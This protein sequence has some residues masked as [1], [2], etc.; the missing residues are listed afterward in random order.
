M[1]ITVVANNAKVKAGGLE[2]ACVNVLI[3]ST[4]AT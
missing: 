4:Y 2:R 3:Y 1:Q